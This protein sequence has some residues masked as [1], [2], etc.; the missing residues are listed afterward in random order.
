[1]GAADDGPV[2]P[3]LFMLPGGPEAPGLD[4]VP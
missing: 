1:M 3:M 4:L 2:R